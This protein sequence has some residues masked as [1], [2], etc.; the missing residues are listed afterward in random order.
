METVIWRNILKQLSESR[1]SVQLHG[2]V[3]GLSMYHPGRPCYCAQKLQ[4]CFSQSEQAED[5]GLHNN[6]EQLESLDAS[7]K[8]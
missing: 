2:Q 3:C 4:V 1:A 8:P 7:G 5:I 6:I